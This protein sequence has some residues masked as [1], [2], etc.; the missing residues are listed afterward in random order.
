M[1][2]A[3]VAPTSPVEGYTVGPSPGPGPGSSPASRWSQPGGGVCPR[4]GLQSLLA[5]FPHLARGCLVH[6]AVALR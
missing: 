5:V 3:L 2:L 4:W 6:Q 1:W